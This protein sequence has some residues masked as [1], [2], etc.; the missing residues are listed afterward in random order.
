MCKVLIEIAQKIMKDTVHEKEGGFRTGSGCKDQIF[1]LQMITENM[2]A[3]KKCVCC[4]HRSGEG[5]WQHRLQ[6]M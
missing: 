4:I 1:N 6:A 2:L 5:M 3:M